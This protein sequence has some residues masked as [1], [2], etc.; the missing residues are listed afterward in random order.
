MLVALSHNIIDADCDRGRIKTT[1]NSRL[2]AAKYFKSLF[3]SIPSK[4]Q[5][6]ANE[7][8]VHAGEKRRCSANARRDVERRHNADDEQISFRYA[9]YSDRSRALQATYNIKIV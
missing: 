9:S 5:A 3:A 7:E 4:T 1:V 2:V 8:V 6:I